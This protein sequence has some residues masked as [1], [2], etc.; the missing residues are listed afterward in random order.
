M[1]CGS[2]M[3]R[4]L[5]RQPPNRWK[6]ESFPFVLLRHAAEHVGTKSPLLMRKSFWFIDMRIK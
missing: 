4:F 6:A 2:P 1:A 3:K 5:G